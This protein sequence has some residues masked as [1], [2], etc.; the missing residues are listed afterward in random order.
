MSEI[1]YGLISETDA[2]CLEKIM[3]FICEEF[4]K[5]SLEFTEIG[6]YSGETG[7]GMTKY[8]T[9]KGMASWW[10]GIDN[11]KDGQE[12][13]YKPDNF[14]V[15]N[16]NEVYNQIEDNS[17]HLIFIDGCHCFAHVVSDFFC[18]ADKVKVGGYLAFHDAG[19]HIKPFKDFQH[20]DKTNPDAYISVRKAL[21]KI[22]LF[23]FVETV[24]GE[25]KDEKDISLEVEYA[26]ISGWELIFDEADET[27][28]A[29]GFCVFKK[30]Y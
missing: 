6:I 3:D 18:Y 28:E 16:S 27:N 8:F 24:N 30:L 14:I 11:L 10:I 7:F 29:G 23:D 9:R 13:L 1:K 15:G 12:V 4:P 26:I 20:G 22:G 21:T 2:C 19:K 25:I 5:D 17:Q